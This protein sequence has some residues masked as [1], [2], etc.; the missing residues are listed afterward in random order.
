LQ[1]DLA[2]FPDCTELLV[3]LLAER[4]VNAA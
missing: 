2:V 3:E 1:R 4:Q